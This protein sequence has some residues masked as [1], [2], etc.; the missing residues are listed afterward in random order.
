M[1]WTITGQSQDEIERSLEDASILGYRH[2]N[3]KIG[4]EVAADLEIVKMVRVF[5]PEAFLW[6][7]ANTSYDLESALAI[8]PELADLGVRI[9]ESPL[10]PNKIAAYQALRKQAAVP[11]FMDEGIVSATEL[12]EFINLKMLDGLACNL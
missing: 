5:A 12:E 9:F 2:F 8:A 7:D 1:S 4:T 11:I 3:I 10:P 6:T